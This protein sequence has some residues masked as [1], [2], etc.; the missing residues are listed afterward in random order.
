MTR[1]N[2]RRNT[3]ISCKKIPKTTSLLCA[4]SKKP[5]NKKGKVQNTSTTNTGKKSKCFII[6]KILNSHCKV[7][8]YNVR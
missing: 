4:T 2:T 5:M 3:P 8:P 1:T 7:S 6:N